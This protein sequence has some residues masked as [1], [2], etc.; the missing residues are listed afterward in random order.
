MSELAEVTTSDEIVAGF[1]VPERSVS[2]VPVADSIAA[3]V[4]AEP[5]IEIRTGV[6]VR[7]VQRRDDDRFDVIVDAADGEF[8]RFDT[9][10]NALWEGRPAVDATLGITPRPW[11]H[12]FRAAI[13]C[14]GRSIRGAQ[15][16]VCTGPSAT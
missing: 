11:S 6:A 15:A 3:A 4:R 5:L 8:A 12:R 14:E 10:V 9:V 7:A 1:R 13:G 2:T 16:T